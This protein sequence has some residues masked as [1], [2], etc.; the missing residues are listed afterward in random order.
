MTGPHVTAAEVVEALR[1]SLP[2]HLQDL[3]SDRGNHFV[4]NVMK[5]L[6][7]EQGFVRVPLAPYRPQS[8]GIAERF[9]RTLKEWLSTKAWLTAEELQ[10]WLKQFFEKYND[11]PHQGRELNGLSPN[12]YARRKREGKMCLASS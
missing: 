2:P 6:E 1:F 10:E 5:E 7:Q 9:V 12:E 11:R 3:I 4:A 8:N